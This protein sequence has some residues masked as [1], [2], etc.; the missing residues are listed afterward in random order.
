MFDGE[1]EFIVWISNNNQ[2]SEHRHVG[3]AFGDI[4]FAVLRSFVGCSY[5]PLEQIFQ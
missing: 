3:S 4:D 1:Y 5:L 2:S